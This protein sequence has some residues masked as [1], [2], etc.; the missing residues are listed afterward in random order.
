MITRRAYI[1]LLFSAV[2]VLSACGRDRRHRVRHHLTKE[3]EVTSFSSKGLGEN[4]TTATELWSEEEFE[5]LVPVMP[6]YIPSQILERFGYIT[7]YNHDT[8]C[9]NWVAWHLTEER[10]DG[11]FPRKG[12]PYYDE[13][14]AAIGIGSVNPETQ[15]G[16]YFLDRESEE[17]RQQLTDWPNNEYRMTHGH[18]CP[19]ADNRWSKAAMNQSF[20]LTNMCP[21]DGSLNGGA[22]QKLEEKCRTWAMQH[23]GIYI[24]SGPIYS[25][26]KISRTIGSS[27][28]AVPDA[29]F[30]VVLCLEGPQKAIG[31]LYQNDS[32]SQSIKNCACSVDS[33]EDMTGFDFFNSLPDNIED[34]VESEA[35]LAKWD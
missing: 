26:G 22:W 33:V 20:L 18:I 19:A 17:P 34:V 28:V 11:P 23:G 35:N 15:R 30:K 14:G 31:F 4:A 6:G 3:K 32:S 29:F 1:V 12:V 5:L 10:T 7:S 21:Q 27:K 2:L 16:D 8:K 9:P 13:D 24:V 25:G